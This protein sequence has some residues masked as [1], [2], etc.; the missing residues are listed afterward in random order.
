MSTMHR[1]W[2]I[3]FC[4][5]CYVHFTIDNNNNNITY[6][7]FPN[8]NY[9]QSP[10]RKYHISMSIEHKNIDISSNT[11][12]GKHVITIPKLFWIFPHTLNQFTEYVDSLIIFS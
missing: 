5:E 9:G 7:N 11:S 6:V 3:C 8:S 10:K 1:P 2:A 12:G 4:K